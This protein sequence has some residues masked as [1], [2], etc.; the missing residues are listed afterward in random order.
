MA[1][2][3]LIREINAVAFTETTAASM[4]GAVPSATAP[5]RL[6][7]KSAG[8]GAEACPLHVSSRPT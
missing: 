7:T 4:P 3:P 1:L 2:Q 5:L 8:Q 6:W